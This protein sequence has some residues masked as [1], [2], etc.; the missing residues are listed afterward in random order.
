MDNLQLLAQWLK[1]STH[2]VVFTGAGMSTESG[3]PDFRSKTGLWKNKDPKKLATI[4]A[5]FQNPEE[6]YN[7]YRQRLSTLGEASPHKGHR[8]LADWEKKRIIQAIITQNVDGLH[9]R[10]G[11]SR[12]IELHGTLREAVCLQCKSTYPSKA[13]LKE[14]IPLCSCGHMLKPGVILF[15]EMLPQEALRQADIESRRSH[16]FI[17]IGSSLEVSPANFFPLEAKGAGAKLVLINL[18]PTEV[19]ERADLLIRDRAGHVLEKVDRILK[20]LAQ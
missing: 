5:M 4:E 9:H 7:F 13:L 12:V 8:I 16:L 15:G 2:T 18:E 10:A 20:T 6:F 1:E 3:L 19:D 17:V 11:S 14:G